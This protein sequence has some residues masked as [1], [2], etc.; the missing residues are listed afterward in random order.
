M[1]N[2]ERFHVHRASVRVRAV[3]RLADGNKLLCVSVLILILFLFLVA[4][5]RVG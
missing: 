2:D 4:L 1:I 3:R 5:L